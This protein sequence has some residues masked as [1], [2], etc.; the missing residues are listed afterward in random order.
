MPALQPRILSTQAPR[1]TGKL[2]LTFSKDKAE[3]YLMN[4]MLYLALFRGTG[5]WYGYPSLFVEGD[6]LDPM[7]QQ[8]MLYALA[9]FILC[10]VFFQPGLVLSYLKRTTVLVGFVTVMCIASIFLSVRMDSSLRGFAAMAL[11]TVPPLLYRLRYGGMQTFRHIRNFAIFSAFAN[12]AYIVAFPRFAIMA[13]SYAG[14]VKGLFYH[15]NGLG[16]FSAVA[17]IVLFFWPF[18]GKAL[19][20][21]RLIQGVA[22]LITLGLVVVSKSSTAVIMVAIGMAVITGM[23]VLQNVKQERARSAVVLTTVGY[24]GL[25]GGGLAFLAITVVAA[26]FG[27]DLTFSGRSNIWGGLVPLIYDK[28]VFGHGFAIFRSPDMIAQYVR[29]TFNARSTHS[30]YL[31]LC[32]DMGVPA[33]FAWIVFLLIRMYQKT[34]AVAQNAQMRI[35]QGREVAVILIIAI[36]AS[37]EAN[38]MFGPS[39]LW[40][41]MVAA[42]PIDKI[43][44]ARRPRRF[45]FGGKKPPVAVAG[46]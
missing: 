35:F 2:G 24:G 5:M 14:D 16:Q 42:L 23:N 12:A 44:K 1:R 28:P 20:R 38:M 46:E 15:K 32:L 39:A 13:G 40:P 21:E 31:E 17:T 37:M 26:A 41:I 8:L 7:P 22:F 43:A 34:I 33:T 10:F 3:L 36:G 11:L 25:V 19:T 6:A 4:F 45:A 18:D 9:P 27:K 29:L 30:T